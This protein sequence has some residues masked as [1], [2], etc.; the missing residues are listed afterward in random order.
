MVVSFEWKRGGNGDPLP[1]VRKSCFLVH[2]NYRLEHSL[3]HFAALSVG[4]NIVI[5]HNK[6]SYEIEVLVSCTQKHVWAG[7]KQE[8]ITFIFMYWIRGVLFSF[9][10]RE[11]LL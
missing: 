4:D 2:L 9:Y 5:Q 6:T 8:T 7:Y 3:R 11:F 1:T 10:F